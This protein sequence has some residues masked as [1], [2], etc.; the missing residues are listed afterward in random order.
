MRSDRRHIVVPTVALAAAL[1]VAWPRPAASEPPATQPTTMATAAGPVVG[2]IAYYIDKCARCHGDVSAAYVGVDHPK[3]G[4]ALEQVIDDMAYGPAQS[5]LDPEGLKQQTALHEAMFGKTPF[6]WIDPT[7]GARVTGEALP[8]T[9]VTFEPAGGAAADVAVADNRF[10]LPRKPGTLVAKR[11]ER[12][13][14]HDV[15]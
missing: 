5:P 11:G 6:V 7:P 12:I 13:V 1:A 2:P 9:T 8:G 15:R 4:K 10:D 3:R 14:K